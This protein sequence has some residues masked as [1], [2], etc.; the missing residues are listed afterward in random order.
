LRA[1]GRAIAAIK[2]DSGVDSEMDTAPL[3]E[4][5]QAASAV[6]RIMGR[7]VTFLKA[8][9]PGLLPNGFMVPGDNTNIFIASDTEDAPLMVAMPEIY[10]TLPEAQRRKLNQQLAQYFRQDKRG[11]FAKEFKYDP[12]DQGQLNE[13][14]P[15]FMVEAVHARERNA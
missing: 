9:A 1:V 4:G 12:K 14:I 7:T 11:E 6:A 15:A 5:Q 8:D 10:H 2:R 13:E 3:S